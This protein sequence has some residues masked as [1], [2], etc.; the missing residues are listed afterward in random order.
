MSD[1]GTDARGYLHSRS[2]GRYRIG[3]LS[4]RVRLG[5]RR[6]GRLAAGTTGAAF[7]GGFCGRVLRAQFPA[8]TPAAFFP[9]VG[10]AAP[11]RCI[12][13]NMGGVGRGGIPCARRACLLWQLYHGRAAFC[14][15]PFIFYIPCR[16]DI[17]RFK[18]L[19][20]PALRCATC[21]KNRL[22]TLYDSAFRAARLPV[23]K[24]GKLAVVVAAAWVLDQIAA[25]WDG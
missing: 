1:L 3:A 22:Y 7:A 19:K 5:H 15:R 12:W 16:L 23:F 17:L 21:T 11:L 4:L 25:R 2:G 10:N 20:S 14:A 9:A 8:R 18:S 13:E 24:I 6:G